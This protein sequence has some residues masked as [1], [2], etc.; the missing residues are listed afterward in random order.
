MTKFQP[1]NP[2][3]L[4]EAQISEL[5]KI[6]VKELRQAIATAN[7]ELKPYLQADG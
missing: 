3:A 1:S 7:P 4:T 6:R 5:S 2:T